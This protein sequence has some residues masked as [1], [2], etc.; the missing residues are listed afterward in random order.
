MLGQSFCNGITIAVKW[1]LTKF[2]MDFR[3]L[4]VRSGVA[5]AAAVL[6]S[7]KEHRYDDR[8]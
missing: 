3:V 1:H 2:N 5:N 4:G 7:I 8:G 6:K